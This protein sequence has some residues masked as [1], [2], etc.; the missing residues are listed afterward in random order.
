MIINKNL[1]EAYEHDRDPSNLAE[2]ALLKNYEAPSAMRKEVVKELQTQLEE[3]IE[4]F[5]TFNQELWNVLFHQQNSLLNHVI[6]VPVVGT[7]DHPIVKQMDQIYLLIDLIQI[8]NVTPIVHQ[9]TYVM[10]N[11]L[12]TELCKLCIRAVYP[13]EAQS[14]QEMLDYSTFCNGLANFIA[15]NEKAA[16]YQFY[17]EKYEPYKERVFG[18]LSSAA[19]IKDRALQHKILLQATAG[20]FWNQFPGAAGMFYFDDLYQEYGTQGVLVRY[21]QG[22]KYF[23]SHIFHE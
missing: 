14:Y 21:Q 12:H 16:Q 15:W 22:W 7:K 9:M 5:P 8:A 20:D 2:F 11:I 18:M 19:E 6:V 3:I 13:F 1:I 17:T 10:Q 4:E 23:V